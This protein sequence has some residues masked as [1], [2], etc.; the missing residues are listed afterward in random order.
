MQCSLDVATVQ[1]DFLP[2]DGSEDSLFLP[3]HQV[4]RPL[5]G[6]C[7]VSDSYPCFT[8]R[9]RIVTG[10]RHTVHQANQIDLFI[11]IPS[12]GPEILPA[13]IP[14]AQLVGQVYALAPVVERRRMLEHLLKPLGV[15]SL[16]AVANGIFANI[17][18]RSGWPDMRV[19]LEDVQ[20]VQVNDVIALVDRVQQ[21]SVESLDGLA[22]I[23]RGSA[24]MAS[25]AA[26]ALL[27][28]VLV[29][30]ARS[31]PKPLDD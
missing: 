18:F 28:T 17:R 14:V 10:R 30:R 11:M 5:K 16:L 4:Y 21:V 2:Q 24:V 15:L 1:V 23:V 31:R 27:V 26:A 6:L 8:V 20:H 22:Q 7:N 19:A 25:S 9:H 12:T 29:R 13:E 3:V